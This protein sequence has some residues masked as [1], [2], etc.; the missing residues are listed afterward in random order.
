MFRGRSSIAAIAAVA[1]LSLVPETR[2]QPLPGGTLDPLTIPKY[3]TPLVVPPAMP[4]STTDK[5]VDYQVA[6]RQ[7][8]QQILPTGLPTTTV[9]GYGSVDH[10][11]SFHSPAFTFEATVDKPVTVKWINGLTKTNGEFLPHLLPVDQTLHWANP[12]GHCVGGTH[13][14]SD[15]V[16][17]D[18]TPYVGPVPIVTHLHG[19]HVRPESDGAPEGWYLP[20]ATNLPPGYATRGMKYAQAA[21]SPSVPGQAIYR[22]SND[23]RATT[24]WYHDHTVGMTRLNVYAGTAGFYLLR[25]GVG[26]AVLDQAG[27]RAVLP[28]PA[29]KLGDAANAQY[30]EIPIAIQDRSF[31]ADG[32]LFYPDSRTFFDGATGPFVPNSDVSPIWNPEFF[33]NTMMVNGRTWPYLEVQPQRYRFRFLNGCDSRF[34]ILTTADDQLDFWQIGS[35]GGFLAVPVKL[36]QLLLGPGERADVVV[37]FS[38]AAGQTIQLL[39]VA[40]DEP[41]GGGVPGVDF[42]AS[43]PA[44]TGQVMQFRVASGP[45]TDTTTPP[46]RLVLPQPVQLGPAQNIRQVSLNEADATELCTT[47]SGKTVL[48]T[49]PQAR[50]PFGPLM[51]QLGTMADGV[52]QPRSFSD[53]V[54]ETPGFGQTEVWEIYNF[55][56]DAHP[57]HLHLVQF[58]VLNRQALQTDA[59]G[60]TTA[61]AVLVDAPRSPENWESG[62][63]DTVVVYPGEVARVKAR[64][65]IRGEYVWHCHI[66]SHEDHEMMRPFVVH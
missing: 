63:K 24:L 54:T 22:Y 23:Q 49:A 10:P 39:N 52:P 9:W 20:A 64:F 2:A 53:E 5:K 16:G 35:D 29:P 15:C 6:V 31:N 50:G 58:E 14:G 13:G 27:V 61:P 51:A 66:L 19:A 32:S 59:D 41:F 56:A 42:T 45:V 7:F 11:S 30:R 26:D 4:K 43:D 1:F 21:G 37:D 25:G 40:P 33:G 28:G 44:T 38:G 12:G 46:D 65:D 17:D 55:T 57:I 48:C 60:M 47:G 34:L 62:R 8:E 36:T 3:V 18:P